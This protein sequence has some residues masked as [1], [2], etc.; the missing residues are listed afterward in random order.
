MPGTRQGPGNRAAWEHPQDLVRLLTELWGLTHPPPPSEREKATYEHCIDVAWMHDLIEDGRKEDGSRV[1][2]A[3]LT[4]EGIDYNIVFGVVSLT[5]D[6]AA[7]SKIAYLARLRQ[8]L[9]FAEAKVKLADRIC[10][11]REGRTVFKDK[12]WARVINET[13]QYIVPLLELI[14]IRDEQEQLRKWLSEA[15]AARP[16]VEGL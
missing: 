4:A 14:E 1:I 10:N 12:R 9:R 16:V 11:L 5:H 6:E 7:D 8:T 3:D 15:I 13:N 2:E